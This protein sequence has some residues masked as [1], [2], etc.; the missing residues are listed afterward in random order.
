M[1]AD[2]IFVVADGEIV[3]QG[4]HQELLEAKGKYSELWSKQIFI[5]PGEIKSSEETSNEGSSI[6]LEKPRQ[7]S[8]AESQED[9]S[10]VNISNDQ[11]STTTASASNEPDCQNGMTPNAKSMAPN[12]TAQPEHLQ[13]PNGHKREVQSKDHS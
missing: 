2:I 7:Q 5:K 1:N 3:E 10:T 4:S 11:E 12:D 13:T 6:I 9:E 8:D